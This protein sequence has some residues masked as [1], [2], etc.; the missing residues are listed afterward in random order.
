MRLTRQQTQ[1]FIDDGYLIIRGAVPDVLVRTARKAINHSLGEEGMDPA[2]MVS[3][4]SLTYTPELRDQPPILDLYH[5]TPLKQI[6]E[7][8]LGE[9]KV[10]NVGGGQIGLRFP[11]AFDADIKQANGH[12][13]GIGSGTNGSNVGDY[14]VG[15]NLL[16]A[17]YL[18]DVPEPF[19]G[20]F[21]V[22]P[23]SHRTFEDYFKKVGH[24]VLHQG[25]PKI[26]LPHPPIH[27]T[28]KAGDVII[29]HHQLFHTAAPNHSDAIRY[30]IFFRI[31]HKALPDFGNA[32][33]TDIWNKF[34]G[35]HEQLG[36]KPE[37]ANV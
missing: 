1:S 29:A 2:K 23:G 5:M 27:V 28:G 16:G 32:A 31:A 35:L 19:S 33:Y 7:Q 20:N 8:L 9:G 34:E 6:A 24:E 12:L 3:Y 25:Q 4:R 22:W 21:T 14:K 11:Q 26:D 30:G 13:D 15:F 37:T 10:A 18:S 36:Y 17:V